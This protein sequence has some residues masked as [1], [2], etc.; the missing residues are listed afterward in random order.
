V[1]TTVDVVDLETAES[2][3]A[4]I[5]SASATRLATDLG[6]AGASLA[7]TLVTARL[8]TPTGR[9]E[10]AVIVGIVSIAFLIGNCGLAFSK[11][12]YAANG[13]I[14]FDQLLG[15]ALASGLG[16]G[17]IT[18]IM[19]YLIT[20]LFPSM[21]DGLSPHALE[22][23]LIFLP[24]TFIELYFSF[25]IIGKQRLKASNVLMLVAKLISALIIVIGVYI[26]PTVLTA[27]LLIQS[28][29][30]IRLVLNVVYMRRQ[31]L[32]VRPAP[33]FRTMRIEF[34]Y[35]TKSR[36]NDV[37][38]HLNMRFDTLILNALS[39]KEAVGIYSIAVAISEF[40]WFPSSGIG[41][42]LFPKTAGSADQVGA[43]KR[44]AAAAR[45]ALLVTLLLGLLIVGVSVPLIPV[46]FGDAF[47]SARLPLA[48]LVFGGVF[49]S[50]SIVL[51]NAL[52]GR[53]IPQYSLVIAGVG[54]VVMI[55]L[56]LVL[57]PLWGIPGAAAA[58]AV[59][60]MASGLIAAF[61]FAWKT[62]VTIGECLFVRRADLSLLVLRVTQ[63]ISRRSSRSNA[64][65]EFRP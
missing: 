41:W 15:N 35:G 50:L 46:A 63:T 61:I 52:A 6:I 29:T 40:V 25:L 22:I 32:L 9:G 45:I 23:G 55:A 28:Y 56:D 37:L 43:S 16:L 58:S 64:T 1:R 21:S 31:G 39:T 34:A 11:T 17:V 36:G 14:P 44:A 19:T 2:A 49:Y 26:R 7:T 30:V 5:G 8:L 51:S 18:A 62:E 20:R 4:G 48:I 54:L 24:M 47:A 53:G 65:V 27:V 38:Q 42:V 13:E 3:M 12:Y 57:I 10:L 33:D 60:Y 59:S